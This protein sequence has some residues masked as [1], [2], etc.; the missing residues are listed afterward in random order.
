LA[1]FFLRL[2]FNVELV[3]SAKKVT[4][5]SAKAIAAKPVAAFRFQLRDQHDHGGGDVKYLVMS[6]VVISACLKC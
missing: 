1:I 6:Q 2:A 5:G 4:S 3:I